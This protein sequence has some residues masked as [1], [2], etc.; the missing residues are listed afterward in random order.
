[1]LR[2]ESRRD[3]QN[4]TTGAT[5]YAL[6]NPKNPEATNKIWIGIEV[7]GLPASAVLDTGAPYLVVETELAHY[8]GLFEFPVE[9]SV[10]LRTWRGSMEG[11]KIRARIEFTS[12]QGNSL[13]FEPTVFISEDWCGPTTVG[14]SSCLEFVNF[15]IDTTNQVFH[16]GKS[17]PVPS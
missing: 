4:F 5:S 17:Y 15:G 13:L 12:T 7:E 3:L 10:N 14:Y 8:L 2:D 1:M 16:F 9:E 11:L 6:A